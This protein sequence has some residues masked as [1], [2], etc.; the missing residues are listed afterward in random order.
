MQRE[1]SP[2]LYTIAPALP[3]VDALAAGILE[4]VGHDPLALAGCTVLLPNRRAC[5]TLREAFLRLSRGSPQLLPRM[6]PIG[7]LD[8]D[9]LS[10]GLS[11]LPGLAEGLALPP[12]MDEVRRQLLLAQAILRSGATEA[13]DQAARLSVELCRLRDQMIAEGVGP[14][15]LDGIVPEDHAR[16][17]QITLDFLKILREVWPRIEAIE[18]AVD[19]ATRSR[20]LLEAQA[21]LWRERPPAGPVI[22]AGHTHV[23]AAAAGLL[24]VVAALPQGMVVLPGLDLDMDERSWEALDEAHPQYELS[25]LLKALGARRADVRPWEDT[26]TGGVRARAAARTRLIAE[27]LR[28]AATTEAWRD[29]E[30]VDAAALAGVTRI[31]CPGP[32]E[33]AAVIALMLREAL[34]T[35]G[36]TAALVTP[37]RTLARR[38]ASALGRWG[39]AIDD[40]GGR[41]LRDTAAGTFLRLVADCGFRQ[42]EPVR[43]LELLK[44]PLTAAGR[45]P[46]TFRAMAR[47][48]ELAVLRGP[49]PGPGFP[50]LKAALA[51]TEHAPEG[52]AAWLDT[53]GALMQPWLDALAGPAPRLLPQWL[54]L[55][56]ELAEA[57]AASNRE[58]GPERLWR[59]EDGEAAARFLNELLRAADG[60]PPLTGAQYVRLFEALMAAAPAVRPRYG[61]HPRLAILGLLEAR[62]QRPDLVILG[63]LNEGTWPPDPGADPWLSRPMRK[64]LGLP[65]PER[66]IGLSAHDFAQLAHADEV[67]LTRSERVDGTPTVP[68]RWLLRLDTVLTR[69]GL[70]RCIEDA[71]ARWLAWAAELDRPEAVR[72]AAP[73]EPRP[74]VR[75]RPR[76]LSVTQV[77]TWMRDPYAIYA[78]HVLRLT[79]LDPIAAD[80]GAA[81]RGQFIHAALDAFL[82]AHPDT[83]PAD[84]VERLMTEGERAFGDHLARPDVWA[85]WW[86]RFERIARWFV[87]RETERRTTVRTLATETRGTLV[88]DGP[89][90]PFTLTGTA[91]RLDLL[92][93]GRLAILDYKTGSPPTAAEIALGF[94]PQ[95]PLEAAMAEAGAFEGL[96]ARPVGE[97][98]FWKLTGGEPAGQE[99]PVG[100]PDVA[101]LAAEA[102]EGLLA[103]IRA[104]D[105]P[106]TPYRALP[107]PDRAPRYSDYAHL[108]RVQEWAAGGGDGGE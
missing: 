89:A 100:E 33:E 87:A 99:I 65:T 64:V 108:A 18:G 9:E 23:S 22:A 3:F 25:C 94:A 49:R 85:F 29:L 74:P 77:E 66:R 58:I 101:R 44:H 47:R 20:S 41:P 98:A 28:P 83:L 42:A 30:D 76:R 69:L 46:A 26:R 56:G 107:R 61:R 37:D 51:R 62:L 103:L 71:G 73:P 38:V 90:G 67:V 15:R 81:E 35:P 75:A 72:P 36:R 2:G 70:D 24:S 8:D 60:F 84:A 17:W 68:S 6:S 14:E 104:F 50:G 106:A 32:R 27:A 88:L 45:D 1:L 7:D 5:R 78:R 86:P 95:L 11:D 80:P 55:H 92:P 12:A 13:P 79:A 31:D 59:H 21:A 39:I 57:L 53:L 54:A 91:D 43:L 102:R 19:A 34:E 97:L 93:D 16:H 40:S 52:L 96:E 63:G 48:L 4:R 105:D 82:R 10:L